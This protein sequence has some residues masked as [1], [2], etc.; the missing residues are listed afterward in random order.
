MG[1]IA[2]NTALGN[3]ALKANTT[4]FDNSAVGE[5]SLY[6]NT[7]GAR[8]TATGKQSLYANNGNDNTA[9]G[10]LT[11]QSN[12][13]GSYNSGVGSETLIT[14]TAGGY[15]TAMGALSLR[16]NTSGNNNTATGYNSL[17][18]NT[19]G[20]GNSAI[21]YN[22]LPSNTTGTYNTALGT[23]A[24]EQSNT[25]NQNTAIGVAAIDRNTTG[26]SNAVLGAFAGRYESDG[27]TYNTLISNSVLIGAETKP[28]ASGETNQIVIGYQ[29]KGN[30]SNT[31]QLGNTSITDVKTSGSVTA[32]GYKIAS[33]TSSQFL[34]A[35]GSVDA[36]TYLPLGGGTL[37]GALNGTS[38][39]F[40]SDISTNGIP[41]GRGAGSNVAN[42]VIGA[43]AFGGNTSGVSNI[44][45]GRQAAAS[46][47][48][49]SYN[50]IV[51]D[52]AVYY[53][54]VNQAI[55]AFGWHALH[56]EKGAGNTAIGYET[57]ARG[58]IAS[59]LTNSTF[60]GRSASAGAGTIDNATA[61]GYGASVTASNTIQLGN[62]SIT[63]VKTSGTITAGGISNTP[64]IAKTFE[65][66]GITL[67]SSYSG[68]IIYTQNAAL[69]AFPE[70][71]PDGFNCVII[72]YS[73]FNFTTNTLAS[74]KFY[75]V[76]TGSTGAAT[77]SIPTGG[78]V[79]INVVTIEGVKR[80]YVN[81]NLL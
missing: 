31:V 74:T 55:T 19:T 60:L 15:N 45:I 47:T 35:D 75:T 61:I 28:S 30:G 63:D 46:S 12:T 81:G 68:S 34:K 79:H 22:T 59:S 76:T 54:D 18:A 69:P 21:G 33:C 1:A 11:L 73:N 23:Q 50:T 80:Y 39:S 13:T 78:T 38:A 36:S 70:D 14:N 4:G 9:T 8:N 44:I 51:G 27:S 29:A 3:Q 32:A 5:S 16:S 41:I 58:A 2:S 20:G 37:T 49:A 42:L 25:A 40:T 65:A 48:S 24:L 10:Y 66:S 6:T 64:V 57:G 77:F 62:T 26:G 7:A 53:N 71:L 56:A 72:N 43:G 52:G 17:Y 67:S